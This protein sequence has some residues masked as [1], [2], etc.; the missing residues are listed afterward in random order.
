MSTE[1]KECRTFQRNLQTSVH[2]NCK[3]VL[4]YLLEIQKTRTET[5]P[6]VF[7]YHSNYYQVK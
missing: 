3:E 1:T 2:G 6:T 7:S 5:K 4:H